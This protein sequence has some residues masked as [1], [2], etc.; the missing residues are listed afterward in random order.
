MREGHPQ[1]GA[2][3][4][5]PSQMAK[6]PS[7]SNVRR[8]VQLCLCLSLLFPA[9]FGNRILCRGSSQSRATNASRELNL[10]EVSMDLQGTTCL[11]ALVLERAICS[12]GV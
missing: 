2:A 9:S 6:K 10:A 8:C 4:A 7:L 1:V 5:W 12:R 11:F 3:K